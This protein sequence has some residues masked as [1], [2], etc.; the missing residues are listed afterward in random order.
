MFNFGA[1]L[2]KLQCVSDPDWKWMLENVTNKEKTNLIYEKM[3]TGELL[4][5]RIKTKFKSWFMNDS[6]KKQQRV[7]QFKELIK[8]DWCAEVCT[9]RFNINDNILCY[10]WSTSLYL[11]YLFESEN[12]F[13]KL[14]I[15]NHSLSRS[16]IFPC[17]V[18]W[19]SGMVTS[20]S[21]FTKRQIQRQRHT[22]TDKDRY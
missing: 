20:P 3:V 7:G 1:G 13:A 12:I 17:S 8:D 9:I 6:S 22:D 5:I 10:I 4:A 11:P 15:Q 19:L 18:G 16:P 14:S 21:P 2:F